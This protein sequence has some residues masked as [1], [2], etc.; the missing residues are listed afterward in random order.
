MWGGI[1][2][3][4]DNFCGGGVKTLNIVWVSVWGAFVMHI[5]PQNHVKL[6]HLSES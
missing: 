2:G 1:V 6:V 4:V 3:G 5:S